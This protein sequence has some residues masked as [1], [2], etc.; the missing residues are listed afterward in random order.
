MSGIIGFDM[1]KKPTT[2]KSPYIKIGT[3]VFLVS[4]ILAIEPQ[5]SSLCRIVVHTTE[6]RVFSV[7]FNSSHYRDAVLNDTIETILRA[8]SSR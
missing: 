1:K 8:N 4:K 7:D 6:G 3:S 5:N 2:K